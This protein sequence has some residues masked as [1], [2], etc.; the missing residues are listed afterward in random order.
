MILD[1]V[2]A[3][4]RLEV[5]AVSEAALAEAL[6]AAAR[7]GF[8]LA[9]EPP[10]RAHLFALGPSEHVLLLLLHHIAGD[11]WSL[12]SAGARSWRAPMRRAAA[13]ERRICRRCRCNMPTTRCGSTRC[14]ASE[15]DPDSAIARQLA[16]WT[17]DALRI[18]PIR[19]ICRPTGHDLR[20][21]AI[22]AT[23]S[24][25]ICADLHRGLLALAR[26]SQAS[27]FMVLQ[28][29]ACGP[30]DPA[31]CRHRHSDRQP[32]CGTHRQC[33]RRS[34][35][36]LRQHPGAAHRH[37]G[38]SELPRADRAGC[39]PA[40]LAAYSH[41]DLPFERLVEVLNPARSLARHPLFQV[42]L[43]AAEQCGGRAST[44]RA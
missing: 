29:G 1:A 38:Q 20:S 8:D 22:A 10:L 2:A 5:V 28:A 21:P 24:A 11:G 16:F 41:Q 35:R 4:P 19:S 39:A 37:V 12:G 25:V 43:V 15:S 13:G 33:A 42:M 18:C 17:D 44:C 14:S 31:G 27:L 30:A 6:A 32:D 7:R 23:A 3:R 9:T 36:L 40:N 26:D 34:G